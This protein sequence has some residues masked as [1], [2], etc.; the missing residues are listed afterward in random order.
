M[1]PQSAEPVRPQSAEPVRP[2]GAEPVSAAP[3]NTRALENPVDAAAPACANDI[4]F[5]R[6]SLATA[7]AC[8]TLGTSARE[9]ATIVTSGDDPSSTIHS[10]YYPS[11]KKIS[12]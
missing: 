6:G 9:V 8:E 2:Q 10:P 1:R 4:G 11:L 5:H 7:V 12:L 3:S